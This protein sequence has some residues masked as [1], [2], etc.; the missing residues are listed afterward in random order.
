MASPAKPQPRTATSTSTSSV[1]AG[2][3]RERQLL[4]VAERVFVERGFAAATM[5]EIAE[6]AGVTKPVVYD[7][8]RSKDALLAACVD[9]G[10][11]E[12]ADR[13]AVAVQGVDDPHELLRR[14]VRAFFGFVEDR[15][16]A[17]A[18]VLQGALPAA[19]DL[20]VGRRRHQDLVEVLLAR[21][22]PTLRGLALGAHAAALSG[23]CERTAVW[24][25]DHPGATADELSELV[26]AFL[27]PGLAAASAG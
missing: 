8:F 3:E 22:F 10:V 2:D 23:A 20:E 9:R 13:T 21:S 26:T 12:L 15:A 19:H 14:A 6:R 25:W 4:E 18:L 11:Q 24:W 7:H 27:W 1:V 16:Q 17:W 5:D